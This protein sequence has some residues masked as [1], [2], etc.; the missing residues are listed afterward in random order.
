MR[1]T[2]TAI[3][4]KLLGC[5]HS[6]CQ[7]EVRHAAISLSMKD[8]LVCRALNLDLTNHVLL[9]NRSAAYVGLQEFSKALDDAVGC[10]EISPDFVK[11][12]SR[13]A[14]AYLQQKG[15]CLSAAEQAW[16]C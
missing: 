8:V 13:K 6:K 1:L 9:S 12:Y 11:G 3:I 5:I 4:L 14:Y 2:P 16:L 10:V 7:V 15:L